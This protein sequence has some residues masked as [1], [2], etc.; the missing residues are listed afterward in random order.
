MENSR[1]QE[2]ISL[3]F[4]CFLILLLA[5]LPRLFFLGILVEEETSATGETFFLLLLHLLLG[6][7]LQDLYRHPFLQLNKECHSFPW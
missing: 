5:L 6:F 7:S 4:F 3:A 1:I 2:A